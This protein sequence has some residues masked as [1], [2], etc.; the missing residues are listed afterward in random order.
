MKIL[1]RCYTDTGAGPLSPEFCVRLIDL[2]RLRS[3]RETP[4]QHFRQE[5]CALCAPVAASFLECFDLL[6]DCARILEAMLKVLRDGSL[7]RRCTEKCTEHDASVDVL[8]ACIRVGQ[9]ATLKVRMVLGSKVD[10]RWVG[11][12]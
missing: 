11:V 3:T 10:Q 4:R 1:P 5:A 12:R 9:Q 2:R 8:T 6:T 7:P